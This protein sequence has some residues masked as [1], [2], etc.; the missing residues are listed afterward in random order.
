MHG[1]PAVRGKVVQHPTGNSPAPV[2]FA[3]IAAK[4]R[5]PWRRFSTYCWVCASRWHAPKRALSG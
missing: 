3:A 5:T 4:E 1:L 2:P